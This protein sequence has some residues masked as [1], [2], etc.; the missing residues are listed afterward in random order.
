MSQPNNY[1]SLPDLLEDLRKLA[2]AADFDEKSCYPVWDA[3]IVSGSD[4][5]RLNFNTSYDVYLLG[6]YGCGKPYKVSS[7]D[8][9]GEG[10]A[11]LDSLETEL[12]YIRNFIVSNE[13]LGKMT[14][15]YSVDANGGRPHLKVNISATKNFED[16][17]C[18]GGKFNKTSFLS[19]FVPDYHTVKM[20]AQTAIFLPIAIIPS[21]YI[22]KKLDIVNRM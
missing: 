14:L 20:Y 13:S 12:D 17:E 11:D 4:Y 22:M 6:G 3:E 1:E 15:R 10:Y 2:T 5:H 19:M 18:I 9:L 8:N 16:D 7:E 21:M